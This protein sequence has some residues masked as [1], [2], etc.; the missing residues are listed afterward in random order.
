MWIKRIIEYVLPME[1]VLE[2]FFINKVLGSEKLLKEFEDKTRNFIKTQEETLERII[3]ENEGTRWGR[4]HGF[5]KLNHKTWKSVPVVTYEQVELYV[6]RIRQGDFRALTNELPEALALTSGTNTESKFILLTPSSIRSQQKG[7]H[8]WNSMLVNVYG[9]SLNKVLILS[10]SQ[11]HKNT[12]LLPV[13]SYTDVVK[14]KQPSYIQKRMIFPKE[15]ES[16]TDFE[17]RLLIA[18]QQSFIRQPTALVSVNP[19]TILKLLDLTDENREEIGRAT[20]R[21]KYI[22]TDIN[23]GE[24]KNKE[25]VLANIFSKSPLNSVQVIGTW[26]GGTQYLFIDELRKKC[27]VPMRDLGFIATEGRFTIPLQDNSPS[28]VLNPFGNFY[29]FMTTD[30]KTIIPIQ[31][32]EHGKEYNIIITSENGLYR[33]D[34]QDIIRMEGFYHQTPIISFQRKDSGFSSMIGEK[35]HENHVLELLN[36]IGTEG[37]LIANVNPPCYVLNLPQ[38]YSNLNKE[39]IDKMLQEINSEYLQKREN[40]R[41]KC[42]E[43]RYLSKQEFQELD[44]KIN[45]NQEHDRFKRKYLVPL[46]SLEFK[47]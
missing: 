11:K 13:K 47:P 16:V 41:L 23:T 1:G 15:A 44:K 36:K 32:L 31:E 30:K 20:I 43:I 34:M 12:E 37:F 2:D 38:K 28:G 5:S 46:G 10:G 39:S 40:N 35:L 9:K 3:E 25:V 7:A 24:I 21:G 42:L 14:E 17:H 27:N 8:I 29:E 6:D 19:I 4:Y 45:P 26:L 18:A 33:Y 22:G